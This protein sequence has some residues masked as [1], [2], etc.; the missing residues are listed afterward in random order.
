MDCWK[1]ESVIGVLTVW[2]SMGTLARYE[3][4]KFQ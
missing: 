2:D 3:L 1:C 4:L